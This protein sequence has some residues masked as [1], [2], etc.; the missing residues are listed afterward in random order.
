MRLVDIAANLT[1]SQ[2]DADRADVIARAVAAGVDRMVVLGLNVPDVRRAVELAG[3]HRGTLFATAGV[4]PHSAGEFGPD[5]VAALRELAALPGIV[6]VGECGFDFAR[7]WSD[8]AS[9]RRCVDAHL[10]LAIETGLPLYLHEREAREAMLDAVGP[11]RDR[12]SRVVVHCFT[13]SRE[14]LEAYLEHDFHVGITGWICDERRGAHLL[15][16]VGLIPE[17]RLMVE[18]DAPYLLPRTL[19]PKPRSR[20]NEPAY[21]SEV[22]RTIASATGRTPE[23]V[24]EASTRTAEAF[25]DFD[26]AGFAP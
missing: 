22:V 24:A 12:L 23:R 20:R 7:M 5:D 3:S 15:D 19:R 26:R 10:E 18:T 14:D 6:A 1:S 2:F 25:F 13:G 9:Q 17:D 4:H 8:E 21:L 16:V 11:V